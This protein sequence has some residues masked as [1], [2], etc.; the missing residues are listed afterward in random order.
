MIDPD[1]TNMP[2][3]VSWEYAFT[4]SPTINDVPGTYYYRL[5]YYYA[6]FWFPEAYVVTDSEAPLVFIVNEEFISITAEDE[7][8]LIGADSGS[9]DFCEK[10]K[11]LLNLDS[12]GELGISYT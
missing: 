11:A 10:S 9:I 5:Y 3:E 1:E 8:G 6:G 2:V 12:C 4:F 7:I